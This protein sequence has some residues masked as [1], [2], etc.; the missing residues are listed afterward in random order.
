MSV[1]LWIDTPQDLFVAAEV[2]C[3]KRNLTAWHY[4]VVF[5]YTTNGSK[6]ILDTCNDMGGWMEKEL[7]PRLEREGKKLIGVVGPRLEGGWMCAWKVANAFGVPVCCTENLC[8]KHVQR[9]RLMAYDRENKTDLFPYACDIIKFKD[10]NM[11]QESFKELP[12]VL[13][14]SNGW[15]SN[16]FA[17]IHT[18]TDVDTYTHKYPSDFVSPFLIKDFECDFVLCVC[19]CAQ[20]R[21]DGDV[22][23]CV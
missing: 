17:P 5:K 4:G 14:W 21:G 3:G 11:E 18:H 10:I 20:E 12:K 22:Q 6:L 2:A 23:G 9:Q 1:I 7:K 19:V 13:K 16:G 8:M 15:W